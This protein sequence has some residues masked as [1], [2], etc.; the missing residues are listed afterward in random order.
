MSP[1]LSFSLGVCLLSGLSLAFR[2]PCNFN[3]QVE[4]TSSPHRQG[5]CKDLQVEVLKEL[6]EDFSLDPQV[7]LDAR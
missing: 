5:I 3:N 7:L 2:D 6:G 4:V 1:Q